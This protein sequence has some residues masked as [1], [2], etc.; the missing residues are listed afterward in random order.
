MNV[1]NPPRVIVLNPL[2]I[3]VRQGALRDRPDE[4]FIAHSLG[5]R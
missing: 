4:Q 3:F 2:A 1:V 5:S